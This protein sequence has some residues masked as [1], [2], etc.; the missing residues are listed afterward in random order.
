MPLP[1]PFPAVL[2]VPQ[3]ARISVIISKAAVASLRTSRVCSDVM[4]FLLFATAIVRSADRNR[5][6]HVKQR[7]PHHYI[8]AGITVY[9]AAPAPHGTVTADA[10]GFVALSI[11]SR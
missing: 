6:P 7:Q 11:A 10:P 5:A 2:D 3:A 4:C 8:R 1:A 9:G